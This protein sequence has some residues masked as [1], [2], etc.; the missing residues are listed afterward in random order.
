MDQTNDDLDKL[1]STHLEERAQLIHDLQSCER[2]IDNLKD[3]LLDK[4][5]EIST[6]S[7]NITEYA[8]Q[9]L[10]LKL[11]IRH[12]EEDLVRIE[13]VLSKAEREAQ[14]I[15]DFQ[16][17]DQQSLNAKM[18]ELMEQLKATEGELEKAKEE[19]TR[20]SNGRSDQRQHGTKKVTLSLIISECECVFWCV[21]AP[22][23]MFVCV[24]RACGACVCVC[25]CVSV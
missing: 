19:N 5:K 7:G 2:E 18:S 8:E 1:N 10:E 11:E 12:K 14:I 22:I 25:V 9:I 13:G 21:C 15:R 20:V 24:L 23:Y 4:D 3:I 16:S 17:S 6:L